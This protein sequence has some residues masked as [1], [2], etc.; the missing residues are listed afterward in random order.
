MIPR[1]QVVKNPSANPGDT[2]DVGLIP[3]SGRSL[4]GGRGNP[5]QYSHLENSKDRG[6][7]WAIV[8]G[9]AKSWTQMSLHACTGFYFFLKNA[10]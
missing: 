10:E 9:L 4:G 6:A 2:R 5:L 3:V 8:H 7:W 1:W